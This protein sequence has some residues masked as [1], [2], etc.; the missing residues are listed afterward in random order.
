M[1]ISLQW[2]VT[3]EPTSPHHIQ[4]RLL[5]SR[6]RQP[7]ATDEM[8]PKKSKLAPKPV[9]QLDSDSDEP[10]QSQ[11]ASQSQ[12]FDSKAIEDVVRKQN[13]QVN[14]SHLPSPTRVRLTTSSDSSKKGPT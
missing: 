1:R 10:T 14:I 2:A 12:E 4:H 5:T 3:S 6:Q 7:G 8:A 13:E 11:E 9:P